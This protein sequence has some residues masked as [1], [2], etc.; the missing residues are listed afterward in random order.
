MR[1]V[2]FSVLFAFLFPHAVL[3]QG[4]APL[5]AGDTF[6]LRLSGVPADEVAQVSAVYTVDG[7]GEVNLPHIGKVR[8]AGLT[9]SAL[10]TSIQTAYRNAEIYTNPTVIIFMATG[11]RFVNVAGEVKGPGRIPFTADMTL[12]RAITAAGDFTQFADEKRVRLL[13]GKEATV[14][15][16]R[17]IRKDP[18]KDIPL[19]PGD[20]V[21]VPQSI[22]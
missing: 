6:E 19:I 22:W 5:R 1:W 2:L 11:G 14:V 8:A 9:T 10:Q 21:L 16:V 13:R 15:D 18:S 7:A 4:D 12:L 20:Q 17:Q 3:A